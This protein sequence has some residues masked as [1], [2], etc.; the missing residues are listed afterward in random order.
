[1][2]RNNNYLLQSAKPESCIVSFFKK[3]KEACD[4]GI[5]KKLAL[6]GV[7]PMVVADLTSGMNIIPPPSDRQTYEELFGFTNKEVTAM[8]ELLLSSVGKPMEERDTI[9]EWLQFYHNGYRFTSGP[10]TSLYC[11]QQVLY[12]LSEYQRW[13][14]LPTRVYDL[15]SRSS[16]VLLQYALEVHPENHALVEGLLRDQ[17]VQ[18]NIKDSF[19]THVWREGFKEKHALWS[20]LYY[21]GNLTRG[22][23]QGTLV[24][25]NHSE[26]EC[27]IE[28]LRKHQVDYTAEDLCEKA[29]ATLSSTGEIEYLL[30]CLQAY[31]NNKGVRQLQA[32]REESLQTAVEIVISELQ[33]FLLLFDQPLVAN[34]ALFDWARYKF[35][36]VL[37]LRKANAV[38]ES[39]PSHSILLELKYIPLGDLARV[40]TRHVNSLQL[41][42]QELLRMSDE[43]LI[44][45]QLRQGHPSGATTVEEL[46][47]QAK[48]QARAYTSRLSKSAVL[49][50]GG[51]WPLDLKSYV[52]MGVGK[53]MLSSQVA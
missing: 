21:C 17:P 3:I 5:I 32:L 9:M 47:M 35:I 22:S 50:K 13:G 26:R 18:V 7:N 33:G 34:S 36:D 4:K 1:V 37:L 31:Y 20:L 6:F 15:N 10:G 12:C 44:R 19:R 40:D 51:I 46:I 43:D 38:T 28:Y 27:L 11:P 53:R 25:P 14:T 39:E 42:D 2:P 41:A 49:Q 8:V 30:F 52:I 16:D 23:A 24:I 48:D 29:L 45:L